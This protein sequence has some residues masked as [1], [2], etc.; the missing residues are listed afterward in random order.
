MKQEK[1]E[2]R[3][4]TVFGFTIWRL[5]A[6]FIIYSILGY[7]VETLFGLVTKGVLESR[8]S[9]LYGPFCAIYGLGAVVVIL[10]LQK[11]KKNNYTLFLETEKKTAYLG[12]CSN[13]ETRM[14][15]LVGIL[16]KEKEN[17]GEI[18]INMNLNTDDAYFRESV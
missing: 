6:Y 13:L 2:K 5:M 1:T 14:L 9:F 15:F 11:F 16:E 10:G 12:D 17:P 18:F 8:K 3:Q 4:F 7:I